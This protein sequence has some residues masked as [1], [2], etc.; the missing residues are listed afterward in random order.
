MSLTV[1]STKIA[2]GA[3]VALGVL[4]G[5]LFAGYLSSGQT[6]KTQADVASRQ[7]VALRSSQQIHPAAGYSYTNISL[8]NGKVFEVEGLFALKPGSQVL[9]KRYSNGTLELCLPLG[10]RQRYCGKAFSLGT[11]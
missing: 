8:A 3:F 6:L 1:Q 9:V 4:A 5:L 10:K 7:Y 2:A 11:F